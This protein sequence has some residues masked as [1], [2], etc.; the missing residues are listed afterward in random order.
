MVPN[1]IWFLLAFELLLAKG[2]KAVEFV[3]PTP[4]VPTVGAN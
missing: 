4:R 1:D 3:I 2:E